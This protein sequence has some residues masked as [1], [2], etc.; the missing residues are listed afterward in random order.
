MENY[1]IY[2]NT[3]LPVRANADERSEM[4]TQL[5]FGQTCEIT[6][7]SG[8]FSKIKDSDDGYEGWVDTKMLTHINES[9]HNSFQTSTVF[10]T[11]VPL[12][13]AF[14]LTDKM[15]YHLSAGSKLPDYNPE[16]NSIEVSGKKFQIHSSFVSYISDQKKQNIAPTAKMFLNTPYLWGGKNILGIDCSG[17]TQIVFSLCGYNLLRDA[18]MQNTQGSA[19]DS[20]NEAETGDLIFFDKMGKITHVGIY[21]GENKIIHA[22]GKVR[23]D[24]IDDTGI[25][26]TETENYTHSLAS[27]RRI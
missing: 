22:S 26:N 5:L 2:L 3:V 8:S 7:I 13:D 11:C 25:F 1:A 10:R 18:S 14:C 23:I 4:V 12:A 27:I 6:E 9:E 15:V 19:I 21:L 20:L 17:F 24:K 16:T